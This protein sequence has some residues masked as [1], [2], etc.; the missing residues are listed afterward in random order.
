MSVRTDL[1]WNDL[2]PGLPVEP[3]PEAAAP[4]P[5]RRP[6]SR[7]LLATV[8]GVTLV[9]GSVVGGVVGA[10]L[11]GSGTTRTVTVPAVSSKL[12]K[13]TGVQAVLAS[14]EP[15]VVFIRTQAS[16]FGTF[17]A[18]SG[19]GTGMILTQDGEVLT[20]AHVVEGASSINVT[21][22]GHGTH[23]ASLIGSD[24]QADIALLKI[25][26]VSGLPTVNLGSSASLQVGDDVV[27]IGNALDLQG[28]LTVTEGIVSALNRTLSAS[29]ESLRGL[30][31]TDAA[32]NPG[33]S[34]GPLVTSDG[35]VV[36]MNT[37]VAGD[38]QN[39]GFAIGV[40]QIKPAIDSLRK[41]GGSTSVSATKDL[42]GY[43]SAWDVAYNATNGTSF[44]GVST[45][46]APAASAYPDGGALVDQV[47]NGT[48]AQQAGIQPGDVIV[49][50]GGQSVSSPADLSAAITAHKP[51]DRIQISW[52]R[53]SARQGATVTLATQ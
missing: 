24:P 43:N 3:E 42:N 19:A 51:G 39:I 18:E 46:S 21:I 14:V 16:R 1:D 12:S 36:G 23:P 44:L 53:G 48:P 41:G 8:A 5:P 13:P 38:A 2:P 4:P 20:N 29:G 9:G 17:F 15:A 10:R 40:D 34:G 22:S 6:T 52:F 28:G 37:A 45:E 30:I 26:G 27:A 32:I 33:N 25:N 49:S 31:Q 11:G 50:A 7:R 35:K 47:Q